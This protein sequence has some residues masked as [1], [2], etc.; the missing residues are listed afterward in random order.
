MCDLLSGGRDCLHNELYLIKRHIECISVAEEL[1]CMA[2]A[3]QTARIPCEGS[4]YY[5]ALVYLFL[6][7]LSD[8]VNVVLIGAQPESLTYSYTLITI[9]SL[10]K[11]R[12]LDLC[13]VISGR[14]ASF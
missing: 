12:T 7:L 9:L 10:L 1:G 5:T 6:L 4:C 2:R 3:L 13:F 8:E 11:N 14:T